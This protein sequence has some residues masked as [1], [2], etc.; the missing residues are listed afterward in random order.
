[1][2]SDP[3]K[4]ID[5]NGDVKDKSNKVV[6]DNSKSGNYTNGDND[7]RVNFPSIIDNGISLSYN[8]INISMKPAV[9]SKA[10]VGLFDKIID[11]KTNKK[12]TDSV[13]YDKV[14]GDNTYITYTPT[15]TGFKEDII[16]T[17]YT[18]QSEFEFTLYTNGL[19][20]YKDISDCEGGSLYLRNSKGETVANLG[21]VIIFTAD[22][23]NNS[24][25]ESDFVTVKENQ[26]YTVIIK[27]DP[28]Y[29]KNPKTVYPV[30]ID[31]TITLNTTTQIED[32]RIT[33]GAMGGVGSGTETTTAIGAVFGGQGTSRMLVKF[34][35]LNNSSYY[36]FSS[37]YSSQII[38]AYIK[39]YVVSSTTYATAIEAYA[40]TTSWVENTVVGNL[41]T[42]DSYYDTATLNTT[43]IG[44]TTG[45]KSISILNT[46]KAWCN[47]NRGVSGGRNPAYGLILI[48]NN[49]GSTYCARTLYTSENANPLELE[50]Q[51]NPTIA[52]T[53]PPLAINIGYS[54]QLSATT[55]PSGQSV[56]WTSQN[57]SI[58]SV[59]SSGVVTAL[60]AGTVEIIAQLTNDPSIT[61]SYTLIV[62]LP[63]GVYYIKNNYSY[64][65]MQ[66]EDAGIT[67]GTNVYQYSKDTS[68]STTQ[69]KQLWKV[70]YLGNEQYSIRPMHKL[71]MGLEISS[72]NCAIWDIGTIDTYSGVRLSAEWRM[73]WQ[74]T[75]YY[76]YNHLY[77][78]ESNTNA[79]AIES[80]STYNEVN[81]YCEPY[82]SSTSRQRWTFE[83][84]TSQP[85]GVI[86]YNNPS[87][88]QKGDTV[89]IIAAVY[90]NNLTIDQSV[91]WQSSNTDIVTIN[92]SGVIT[93]LNTGKVIITATSSFYPN[94]VTSYILNIRFRDGTY[95]IKNLYNNEYIT[96][97]SNIIRQLGLNSSYD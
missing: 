3:V 38:S 4:Y 51:Y 2:Y 30:T 14:F 52:I 69:L 17:E 89:T 39:T 35:T 58:A 53:S 42:W 82:N 75:G 23:G 34:P 20:L 80:A 33:I 60:K 81:I 91:D 49:E 68:S 59:S 63:N 50:I 46:V 72:Y 22:N 62:T 85:S 40:Y 90:S 74:S 54:Y 77:N 12:Q 96:Y 7:I 95:Y 37:L 48:N 78:G 25:G 13:K 21:Q 31:P 8:D 24:F 56:S 76:L 32:A 87:E 67:D 18:G 47:Y 44:I 64:K 27:V 61:A 79:L 36:T 28:D 45:D 84:V 9:T 10:A 88:I 86:L 19:E 6:A 71:N 92:S 70:K 55:N 65:Y 57:S 73:Q 26:E 43:Y 15:Y 16:L 93:A 66:V 83:Q 94:L 11:F 41:S 5:K 97:N 29:L 1:M